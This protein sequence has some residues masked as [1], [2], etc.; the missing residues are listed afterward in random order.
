[1]PNGVKEL[2]RQTLHRLNPLCAM[3]AGVSVANLTQFGIGAH[4]LS[5]KSLIGL[6]SYIYAYTKRY[7][8]ETDSLIAVGS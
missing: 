3:Y 6:A 2:R 5:D 7:D 8:P 4:T 1:M